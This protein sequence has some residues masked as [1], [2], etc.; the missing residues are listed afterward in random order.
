M[1]NY[2]RENEF[3]LALTMEIIAPEKKKKLG[4][5]SQGHLHMYSKRKTEK[6]QANSVRRACNW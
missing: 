4:K 3:F 5:D 1:K 2:T 6:I